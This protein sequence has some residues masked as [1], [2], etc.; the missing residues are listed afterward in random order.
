[1]KA[2]MHGCVT[3][4]RDL[5]EQI[6]RIAGED[7]RDRFVAEAVAETIRRLRAEAFARFVG[8]LAGTDHPGWETSEAAAEWVHN[9]RYHPEKFVVPGSDSEP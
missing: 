8:S 2:P 6:D 7:G 5:I 9:L 1:M 4:S 3:L